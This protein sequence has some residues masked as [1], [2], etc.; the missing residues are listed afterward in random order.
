MSR[1]NPRP[2]GDG[3][4]DNLIEQ[5]DEAGIHVIDVNRLK[6][7]RARQRRNEKIRRSFKDR[8]YAELAT[9]FGLSIR[10]IRRIVH[11]R[12]DALP[13]D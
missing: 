4:I 7:L 8:N 10:Q 3:D 12:H 1:P 5:L 11:S 6:L 13:Q 2:F 9:R